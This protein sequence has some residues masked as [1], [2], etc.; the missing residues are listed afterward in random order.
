MKLLLSAASIL[1]VTALWTTGHAFAVEPGAEHRDQQGGIFTG[2]YR[3]EARNGLPETVR[4]TDGKT[5]LD[6]SEQEY[7][8]RGYAP[9]FETLWTQIVRRLPVRIQVPQENR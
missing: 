7:R 9:P 5:F 4:V 6:I 1:L 3:K 2:L 8:E